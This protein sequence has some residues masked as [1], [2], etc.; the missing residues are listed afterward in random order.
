MLYR[1][2]L[3]AGKTVGPG[4]GEWHLDYYRYGGGYMIVSRSIHSSGENTPFGSQR[5]TAKEMLAFLTG[6]RDGLEFKQRRD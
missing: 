4:S 5:R 3:T 1:V 2:A 6:L